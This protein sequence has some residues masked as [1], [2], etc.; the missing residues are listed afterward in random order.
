MVDKAMEK[1]FVWL[2]RMVK[3]R[4]LRIYPFSYPHCNLFLAPLQ[5]HYKSVNLGKKITSK[6]K[7]HHEGAIYPQYWTNPAG[8]G[9][10]SLTNSEREEK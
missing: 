2:T 7:R 10:I 5:I 6:A 9:G 3:D 4:L 8:K 1:D